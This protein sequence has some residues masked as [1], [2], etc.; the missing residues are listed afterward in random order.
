MRVAL[1]GGSSGI[2]AEVARKLAEL[3][4]EVTAF[5]ISEPQVQVSRWIKTDLSDPGSIQ[6]A[7]DAVSGKYDALINNA[8]LPPRDGLEEVILKVNWFGLRRFMDG[9][10]DKLEPGAAIVNT[11]SRA[12]A[13]WRDNLEEVKALMSL[14]PDELPA[15]ISE[16]GIDATRAY[17]LSKEAVIVMTMAE[18]ENLIAR[19]LRMNSVSPAAVSTGILQDFAAAFGDRMVKNVARAGRPGLPEE[20]AE[21]IVFLA[22]PESGWIKGQD[23]TI[24]GGMNAMSVSDKLDL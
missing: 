22:S 15:F 23:I 11:A 2:G 17:N 18:T 20:V 24:D 13:M 4:H 1:T 7:T 5:D 16:R 9:M 3:G 12:G 19:N 21:V 6:A 8:G 10:L 14:Q